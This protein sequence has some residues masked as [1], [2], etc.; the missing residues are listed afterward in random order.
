MGKQLGQT[1]AG[2]LVPLAVDD[3]GHLQADVL[4]GGG[5]VGGATLVEQQK[6]TTALEL[7]DDLRNALDSVASDKLLSK[8]MAEDGGAV[9][10]N[11]LC[12]TTGRLVVRSGASEKIVG[13][14][15]A[16]EEQIAD[17]NLSAGTNSLSGTAVPSGKIWWITMLCMRYQGT[18][19]TQI[20]ARFVGLAQDM[21][22]ITQAS[23]V[24]G[25]W[26]TWNGSAYL[27]EGDYL[28]V[29]VTGATAGDDLHMRYAGSEIDM[30]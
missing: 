18:V 8:L 20:Y 24:S 9:D 19:P 4:S 26:Y 29:V 27:L 23:P 22:P 12:D 10:R 25:I 6:H 13:F 30:P 1:S 15:A 21:T 14:G 5:T 2:L 17:I 16:A 3:D 11:L 7:I 28:N